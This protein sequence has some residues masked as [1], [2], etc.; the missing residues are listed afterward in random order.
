M[1]VLRK[2]FDYV[3]HYQEHGHAVIRGVFGSRD[4]GELAQAFDRVYARAIAHR[5]SFRHQNIFFQITQ[6]PKLGRVVRFAQWPSYFDKVLDRYRSDPRML[7]IIEPLIGDDVKQ[8]IN[9][10]FPR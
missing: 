9:P 4:I 6:D 3:E 10:A 7:A 1:S 5:T 8:I 2:N